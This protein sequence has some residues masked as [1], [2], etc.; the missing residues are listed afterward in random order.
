MPQIKIQHR[1]FDN[2]VFVLQLPINELYARLHFYELP[3]EVRGYFP[4]QFQCQEFQLNRDHLTPHTYRA[5][6]NAEIMICVTGGTNVHLWNRKG[7]RHDI[8]LAPPTSHGEPFTALYIPAMIWQAVSFAKGSILS[9]T[10][11]FHRNEHLVI[12]HPA[13]Y[14][15]QH[16]LNLYTDDIAR[17]QTIAV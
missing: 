13:D 5:G 3:D 6:N 7:F 9:I 12:D 16:G 1:L 10:T 4:S 11:S 14:F 2:K 17:L 15:D 8:W